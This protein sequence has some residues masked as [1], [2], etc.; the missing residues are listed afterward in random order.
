MQDYFLYLLTLALIFA[1]LVA[2]L[3]MLM[4]FANLL[5]L[6]HA[7]YFG[8]GAYTAGY[9]VT[10]L[11]LSFWMAALL[12]IALTSTCAVLI[13]I[14]LLRLRDDYFIVATLGVQSVIF[15]V[16]Y[17]WIPVTQG[18][19]GMSGL[20]RPA[21]LSV[22][23][24]PD[25]LY[26]LL[27]LAVAAV[28]YALMFRLTGSPVGRILRGMREDEVMTR[29]LGKNVDAYKILAWAVA[30]AAAA[31]AGA[32]YGPLLTTI[33]PTSFDIQTSVLIFLMV[34][35]GGPGNLWGSILGAFVL[36]LLPE[37]L[38]FVGIPGQVAPQIRLMLYGLVL[39]VLMLYR[40]QGLIG[41]HQM[42]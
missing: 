23:L 33:D 1:I 32:L 9:A 20:Q 21:L 10:V 4:G 2:S 14:P 35:V 11:G 6:A 7:A 12:A 25:G 36:T 3:N 42:A 16:L 15:E 5:S 30:G 28:C 8:L 22:S 39:I 27:A 19:F 40:R 34:V 41:E 29:L 24:A 26:V 17:N 37:A 38:R 31:A 18:P 13:A